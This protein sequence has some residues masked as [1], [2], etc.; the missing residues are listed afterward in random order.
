MATV[1]VKCR[2]YW[3]TKTVKRHGISR[4][5]YQRYRCQS[6]FRTF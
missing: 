2:F 3:H 6:Y 1:D 4:V 5:G